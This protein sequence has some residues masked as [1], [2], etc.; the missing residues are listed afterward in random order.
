MPETVFLPNELF[1]D[2]QLLYESLFG[3]ISL[4]RSV[5]IICQLGNSAKCIKPH[6]RTYPGT[7]L[8]LSEIP[9]V[10]IYDCTFEMVERASADISRAYSN[11]PIVKSE[12][13]SLSS[14]PPSSKSLQ[15]MRT[16]N[17]TIYIP[18]NVSRE[19]R[20][21]PPHPLSPATF[22]SLCKVRIHF[23]QRIRP[24]ERH[25]PCASDSIPDA[26]VK[27]ECT[28]KKKKK[29]NVFFA[30]E[31]RTRRKTYAHSRTVEIGGDG[32]P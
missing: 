7:K 20:F 29:V 14:S 21:L 28:Q 19:Q 16:S 1:K 6:F 9:L 15:L 17:R 11:N 31:R 32:T 5:N 26:N 24:F 2:M 25:F 3:E 30:G 27:A 13:S 4:L 12:P 18:Q 10:F 23:S 8:T 22:F